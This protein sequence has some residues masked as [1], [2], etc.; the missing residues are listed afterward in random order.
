[1][2]IFMC[3][4]GWPKEEVIEFWKK[5]GNYILDTKR[6]RSESDFKCFPLSAPLTLIGQLWTDNTL[7]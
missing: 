2:N 5:N 7:F 1:M 4:K 6:L 3:G